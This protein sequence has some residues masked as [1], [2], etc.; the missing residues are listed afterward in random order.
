VVFDFLE[1]I[2]GK[3]SVVPDFTDGL[4]CQ[5]VLDAVMKSA[6]EKCWINVDEM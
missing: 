6:E 5:Q 3:K 4:K 1:G 2:S